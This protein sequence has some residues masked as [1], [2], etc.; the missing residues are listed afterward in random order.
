MLADAQRITLKVTAPRRG[1]FEFTDRVRDFLNKVL[2]T[3]SDA[4]TFRFV[5]LFLRHT[6]AALTIQENA[7]PSA[8]HDLELFFDRLVPFHQQ[9]FRHTAEGPDDMPSHIKNVLMQT[10]LTIPLSHGQMMLGRWQ[11]IYLW[12]HRDSCPTRDIVLSIL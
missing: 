11:G 2:P 7:D 5:H 6:S 8:R 9:G 3:E 12:E 4:E 1:L 10:T